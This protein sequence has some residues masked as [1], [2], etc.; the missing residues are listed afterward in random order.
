MN[1]QNSVDLEDLQENTTTRV[2]SLLLAISNSN[3]DAVLEASSVIRSS[4]LSQNKDGY[5][6][7]QLEDHPRKKRHVWTEVPV[8]GDGAKLLEKSPLPTHEEVPGRIPNEI[9]KALGIDCNVAPEVLI[10]NE[11]LEQ[12][13]KQ[14]V[15]Y[16]DN[17][18][19]IRP[20]VA[21]ASCLLLLSVYYGCFVPMLFS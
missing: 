12:S 5:K 10:T 15:P 16:E 7:I 11:A 19:K 20:G 18:L 1:K 2:L 9:L 21:K 6:H 4:R 13:T 17:Q 3:P 14:V 8:R